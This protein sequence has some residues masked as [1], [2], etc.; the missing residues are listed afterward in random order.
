MMMSVEMVVDR[1]AERLVEWAAEPHPVS[2]PG[3]C[4]ELPRPVGVR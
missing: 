4:A 3:R 1:A 2:R